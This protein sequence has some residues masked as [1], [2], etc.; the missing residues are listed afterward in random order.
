MLYPLIIPF[1]ME[2]GVQLMITDDELFNVM[3][4]SVGAVLGTK[5]KRQITC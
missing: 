2:G 4:T 5:K 3:A 1:G